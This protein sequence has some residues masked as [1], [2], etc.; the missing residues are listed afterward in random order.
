MKEQPKVVVGIDPSLTQTAVAVIAPDM[1]HQI[2]CF[3]SKPQGKSVRARN[4][5]YNEAINRIMNFIDNFNPQVIVIESYSY[6][7]QGQQHSI[8]EFGGILRADL[9]L[10]DEISI[11]EVPP[12]TLKKFVT[13]KGNAKKFQ[14]GIAALKNW[15]FESANDDECD[16][17]GLARFAAI[18]QGYDSPTNK[19]QVEALEG[20]TNQKF[21][22]GS[23]V[24]PAATT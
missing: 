6:G 7:S 13:G 3:V 2:K 4:R 14:M 11:L 16:A 23:K 17:Y 20:I 12:T 1:S 5:R 18:V 24:K 8:A 10:Y 19:K 15:G 22:V 21:S 9:C